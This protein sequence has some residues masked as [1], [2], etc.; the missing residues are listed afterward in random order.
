MVEEL[1]PELLR[2][3]VSVKADLLQLAFRKKRQ[4]FVNMGYGVAPEGAGKTFY[5]L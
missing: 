4:E 1:H 3:E 2:T 5:E